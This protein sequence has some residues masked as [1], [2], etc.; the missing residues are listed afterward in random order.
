M[1]KD[2]KKTNYVI[3]AQYDGEQ[4]LDECVLLGWSCRDDWYSTDYMGYEITTPR[5]NIKKNNQGTIWMSSMESVSVGETFEDCKETCELANREGYECRICKL[6][7]DEF[8]NWLVLP[9]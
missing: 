5:N 1:K 4:F 8:N 9:V 3:V 2:L 6:E 7:K